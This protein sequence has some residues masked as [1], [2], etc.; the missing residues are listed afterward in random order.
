M[1]M[2][3][4]A[5]VW[6]WMVRTGYTTTRVSL[7]KGARFKR[8]K[9]TGGQMLLAHMFASLHVCALNSSLPVVRPA[10]QLPSRAPL[11]CTP[12]HDTSVLHLCFQPKAR[13]QKRDTVSSSPVV[14]PAP[15]C[16]PLPLAAMEAHRRHAH[17]AHAGTPHLQQAHPA[18]KGLG[19]GDN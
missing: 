14:H 19:M 1:G 5:G 2:G 9:H 6:K 3:E 12:G 11:F 7:M 17:C 16:P 10:P 18:G 8:P 13:A 4:R 15:Q